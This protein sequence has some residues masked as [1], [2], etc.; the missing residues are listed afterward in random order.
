MAVIIKNVDEVEIKNLLSKLSLMKK[1]LMDAGL[2]QTF[3]KMEE[4]IS[5]AGYEA[6]N[7]LSGQGPG[8]NDQQMK[9]ITWIGK[10]FHPEAKHAANC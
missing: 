5:Y 7:L 2:L 10:R 6:A 3:H 9:S 8:I 1:E 4:V